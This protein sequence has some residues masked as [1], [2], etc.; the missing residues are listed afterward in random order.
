MEVLAKPASGSGI[1]AEGATC[2]LCTTWHG[3]PPQRV[4]NLPHSKFCG[5]DIHPYAVLSWNVHT[6]L[7]RWLY[8]GRYGN[9]K[10]RNNLTITW[11]LTDYNTLICIH[12]FPCLSW[13]DCWLFSNAQGRTRR[14]L[15]YNLLH[16]SRTNSQPLFLV[17]NLSSSFKTG[18]N[19]ILVYTQTFVHIHILI[20]PLDTALKHCDSL[21]TAL[22]YCHCHCS[23]WTCTSSL[24]MCTSTFYWM[25]RFY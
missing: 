21:D 6:L 14:N 8:I 18:F 15:A 3:G 17:N 1:I 23:C 22:K 4:E 9:R 2:W 5:E 7:S 10:W 24:H 11:Y 13:F 19:S 16:L 12:T 20:F 25:N